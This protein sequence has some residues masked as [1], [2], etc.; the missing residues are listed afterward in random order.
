[1]LVKIGVQLNIVL[2]GICGMNK[3]YEKMRK[4]FVRTK[5]G[6]IKVDGGIR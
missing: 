4:M 1:M 3:Y 6:G 5:L 2:K